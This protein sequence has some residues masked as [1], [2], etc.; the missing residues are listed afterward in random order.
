MSN[1]YAGP[2]HR[3]RLVIKQLANAEPVSP[4]KLRKG[5]LLQ[6]MAEDINR[7]AARLE[8]LDAQIPAE[9]NN[10]EAAPN[11][12]VAIPEIAPPMNVTQPR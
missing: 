9:N 5:D 11:V 8:S 1:K 6:E 4:V 10:Q 3:M 2:L 12:V 7:V